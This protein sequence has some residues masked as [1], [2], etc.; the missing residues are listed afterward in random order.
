MLHATPTV[1][2]FAAVGVCLP[3][4][5]QG[6]LLR[7]QYLPVVVIAAWLLFANV[8]CAVNAILWT[9]SDVVRMLAWCDIGE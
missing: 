4:T 5:A 3:F 1:A 9:G 6:T 8:V 2:F 7:R